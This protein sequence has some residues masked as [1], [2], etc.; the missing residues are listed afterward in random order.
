[1]LT[2]SLPKSLRVLCKGRIRL[3][4]HTSGIPTFL[5]NENC[6]KGKHVKSKSWYMFSICS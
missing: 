2:L 3:C 1:M 4:G 5:L 6:H